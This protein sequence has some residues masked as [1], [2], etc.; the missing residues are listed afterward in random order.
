MGATKPTA[1]PNLAP[2]NLTQVRDGGVK[3]HRNPGN[4]ASIQKAID[5]TD[6]GSEH[7]TSA[8]VPMLSNPEDTPSTA[9]W[10][11]LVIL[12]NTNPDNGETDTNVFA[13]CADL[14]EANDEA[15]QCLD[16][17]YGEGFAWEDYKETIGRDGTFHI[18][19][20]GGEGEEMT[21]QIVKKLQMRKNA[22][23]T[24]TKPKVQA[25]THVYIVLAETRKDVCGS[26]EDGE[27]EDIEVQAVFENL[28]AAESC[29]RGQVESNNEDRDDLET[30]EFE[31]G[32]L[33]SIRTTDLGEGAMSLYRIVKQP[34][35]S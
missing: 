4:S 30:E 28:A 18:T 3:K 10:V 32:G 25:V 35:I 2:R 26:N 27:I 6:P 20:R 24:S 5:L 1:Q 29:L 31:V 12:D 23:P 8:T 19:A 22:P 11:Y 9:E 34:L 17:E 14:T 7:P 15:R 13:V 16:V 21:V 33:L